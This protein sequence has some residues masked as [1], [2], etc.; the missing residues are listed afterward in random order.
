MDKDDSNGASFEI[1]DKKNFEQASSGTLSSVS[2]PYSIPSPGSVSLTTGN[3][4]SNVAPPSSIPDFTLWS[5][6]SSSSPSEKLEQ[7][8][9]IE[10]LPTQLQGASL[11]CDINVVT[12]A[13]VVVNQFPATKFSAAIPPSKGKPQEAPHHARIS[14]PP[15]AEIA[16]PSSI[17]GLVKGALSSQVV[18][19]MVEKAKSSVDSIITTLDPQMSEYIYSG[20]DLE[21][22]VTTE[23]DDIVSGVREAAH[24][25]L[26]QAWVNGI[27][28]GMPVQKTQA[29]GFEKALNNAKD[30]IQYSF[31]FRKT[32]TVAIE[33]LLLE[34][35]KKWFDLSVLV[36]KDFEKDIN[37]YTFSQATPVP[38]EKFLEKDV[39]DIDIENK[40]S[41]YL[42]A[43]PCWQEEVSGISRKEVISLSARL[44]FKLYKDN[45]SQTNV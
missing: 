17:L 45:L 11:S 38:V 21:I 27:K 36:L 31:K 43:V 4:L 12:S 8:P 28:L 26:G 42:K 16:A 20:G 13:P 37:I 5:S 19:K 6:A 7:P 3:L 10:G 23:E 2:S 18:T 9:N 15:E 40:L 41:E 22:T 30:K 14:Q 32:V 24:S 34:H 35:K 39:A 44:L 1:I 29:V 33:N 25:V